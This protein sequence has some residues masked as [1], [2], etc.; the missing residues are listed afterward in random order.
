MN[1]ADVAGRGAVAEFTGLE[2]VRVMALEDLAHGGL[3]ARALLDEAADRYEWTIIS[4]ADRPPRTVEEVRWGWRLDRGAVDA[5]AVPWMRRVRD[6]SA[7]SWLLVEEPHFG[8]GDER[9]MRSERFFY[10]G[11]RIMHACDLRDPAA[12]LARVTDASWSYQGVAFAVTDDAPIP[13][14]RQRLTSEDV[15]GVAAACVAMVLMV[16]DQES[17]VLGVPRRPEKR[18]R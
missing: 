15:G 10:V 16:H 17:F 8:E 2:V 1:R 18:G 13:A 4:R 5:L 3:I 7:A 6:E 12:A 11:D 9:W 14:H